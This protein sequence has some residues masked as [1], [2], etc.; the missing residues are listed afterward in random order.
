M[1]G[2]GSCHTSKEVNYGLQSDLQVG[3]LY[4]ERAE[5]TSLCG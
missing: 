2:M 5:K 4:Q 3:G 1:P